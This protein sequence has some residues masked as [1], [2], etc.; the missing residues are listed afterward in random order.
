MTV[1]FNGGNDDNLHQNICFD[2]DGRSVV[3]II[4]NKW[5]ESTLC[6]QVI[7]AK[8]PSTLLRNDILN[9]RF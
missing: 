5:G 1:F 2:D 9:V 7:G 3:T 4:A 8:R 6:E